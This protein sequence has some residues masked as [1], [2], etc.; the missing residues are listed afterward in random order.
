M[1]ALYEDL[2]IDTFICGIVWSL[3]R[4]MRFRG[5]H[6]MSVAVNCQWN[7]QLVKA[8]NGT[9]SEWGRPGGRLNKKDGLTGYG[10]SHVKDKTS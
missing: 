3:F 5:K 1:D 2:K 7:V 10:D 9:T 6:T 8:V 4:V